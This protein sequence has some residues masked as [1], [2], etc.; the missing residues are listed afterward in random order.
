M[1]AGA[2]VTLSS[3]GTLVVAGAPVA[4]AAVNL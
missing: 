1:A 3:G 4:A 2:A